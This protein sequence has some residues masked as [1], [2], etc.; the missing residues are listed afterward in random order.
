MQLA[1]GFLGLPFLA[2]AASCLLDS[3]VAERTVGQHVAVCR[4]KSTVAGRALTF[5]HRSQKLRGAGEGM[6]RGPASLKALNEEFSSEEHL[7]LRRCAVHCEFAKHLAPQVTPR[8]LMQRDSFASGAASSR[9]DRG[10]ERTTLKV[11]K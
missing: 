11:R 10:W 2:C 6:V 7:A 3:L 9:E 4:W 8:H 1:L 5:C